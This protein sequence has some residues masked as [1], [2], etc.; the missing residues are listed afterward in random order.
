MKHFL[1]VA[2]IVAVLTVLV[3]FGLN[4]IGL[5]PTQSSLQATFIDELFNL[6]VWVISFLFALIV[7]FILYSVI[8][9]RRRPGETGDGDYF[10]G[11]TR[12]ELIWTAIPLATV[13]F[14][15]FL[16]SKSLAETRR[17]DP[18]AI[19]VRVIASQWSWR[20]E[21]SDF[22]FSSTE[23][24]LPVNQQTLLELTSTDVIHSFWV[25][26]FRVKQDALPGENMERELRITPS[27]VGEYKVRCAEL[28]GLQHAYMNAQVRV[29]EVDDYEAWLDGQMA[30]PS[31]E[32]AERGEEWAQ[33]FGCIACHT[34][35]G[36][37]GVGPTWS[38]L[39]DSERLLEDGTTVIA[40]DQY[41]RESILNPGAKIVDGYQNIMPSNF[42]DQ[43]DDE[44]I[45]D[46][47][48][49]IKSL[50]Q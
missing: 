46:V 3:G 13:L 41:L 5:L 50:Q 17:A 29:L 27:E 9:F 19:N 45:D 11:N 32:A 28:C 44:K 30:E 15:S 23:L 24:V 18:N 14:F 1:F 37:Q 43:M 42:S 20:F 34:L 48:A 49:F 47:I 31:G 26:E 35:D 25:P 12:L 33:Q 21:Y 36:S 4:Q 39:F 8:V 38:G 10:E 6:H 7:G 2:V 40:N 16:G 22:G